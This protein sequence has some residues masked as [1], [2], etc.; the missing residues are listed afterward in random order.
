MNVIEPVQSEL[1]SLIVFPPKKGGVLH[2]FGDRRE[3]DAVTMKKYSI[4][5]MESSL[6]SFGKVHIFST[7]NGSSGYCRRHIFDRTK[8]KTTFIL[9]LYLHRLLWTHYCL[10]HTERTFPPA[11]V[12]IQSKVLLQ[13]AFVHLVNFIICLTSMKNHLWRIYTVLRL[14]LGTNA[15]L[16]LKKCFFDFSIKYFWN[17][18]YSWADSVY[19]RNRPMKFA[20]Y[21]ILRRRLYASCYSVSEACFD[22]LYCTLHA[23]ATSLN[24]N[25]IKDELVHFGRLNKTGIQD[26][27]TFNIDWFPRYC[28]SKD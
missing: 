15:S 19:W 27:E 23:L 14:L 12:I 9:S 8:D 20:D 17:I 18:S 7:V 2:F 1:A 28:H 10:K 4:L 6:K 11:I 22:G 3:L 24:R 16:K 5:R 26:H 21:N 25:L 13:F